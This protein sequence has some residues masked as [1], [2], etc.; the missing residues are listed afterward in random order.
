MLKITKD[1]ANIENTI[2]HF[3]NAQDNCLYFDTCGLSHTTIN[4]LGALTVLTDFKP[5]LSFEEQIDVY[6]KKYSDMINDFNM[7]G[8]MFFDI[9]NLYYFLDNDVDLE[10]EEH[11]K[12]YSFITDF[13]KVKKMTDHI[14]N[15]IDIS[16]LSNTQKEKLY[17]LAY[18][19]ALQYI[20]S[21]E[22]H[23]ID[24]M[25]TSSFENYNY[26]YE[27]LAKAI[28]S[29][30]KKD[31]DLIYGEEIDSETF[32]QNTLMD[33]PDKYWFQLFEENHTAMEMLNNDKLK[34]ILFVI[35]KEKL[36]SFSKEFFQQYDYCLNYN[37]CASFSLIVV[38]FFLLLLAERIKT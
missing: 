27:K 1:I 2:V 17:K 32:I 18:F 6:N 21:H 37:Q 19:I 9:F 30:F 38:N 8:D 4:L 34:L 36:I 15:H 31:I 5:S 24:T 20:S 11:K 13:S 22:I 26:F 14:F 12:N 16:I 23:I 25:I 10:F 7:S 29:N 35:S 3:M 33:I 28:L